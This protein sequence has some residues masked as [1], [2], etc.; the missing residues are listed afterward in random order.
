[1]HAN[2]QWNSD[3]VL[4]NKIFRQSAYLS[5]SFGGSIKVVYL[6]NK[7]A[8]PVLPSNNSRMLLTLTGGHPGDLPVDCLLSFSASSTNY[9]TALPEWTFLSEL[10]ILLLR[11]VFHTRLSFFLLIIKGH[12]QAPV[13]LQNRA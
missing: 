13:Q 1:M 5:Q 11:I 4:H 7:F 9:A 12:I 8:L 3:L 2:R 6:I 10:I